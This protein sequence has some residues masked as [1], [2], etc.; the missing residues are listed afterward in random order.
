MLRDGWEDQRLGGPAGNDESERKEEAAG[1]GC[2]VTDMWQIFG[3][4]MTNGGPV[5]GTIIKPRL[6]LQFEEQLQQQLLQQQRQRQQ[7]REA[8]RR[9]EEQRRKLAAL[10]AGWRRELHGLERRLERAAEEARKAAEEAEIAAKEEAAGAGVVDMG[11][12]P[13][14]VPT[15]TWGGGTQGGAC[16]WGAQ[17]AEARDGCFERL[18]DRPPRVP[19]MAHDQR[20]HRGECDG[21]HLRRRE[22]G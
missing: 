18:G 4:G 8:E 10:A 1:A 7:L 20:P 16:P 15:S 14:E 6:D 17:P 11:R 19:G 12:S 13:Q 9:L 3:R 22:S 5:V 2:S 21:A